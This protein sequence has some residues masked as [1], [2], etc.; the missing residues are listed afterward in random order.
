MATTPSAAGSTEKVAGHEHGRGDPRALVL[1]ALG[2]VYG[3]IGTSPLY[4][5]REAFGHAGGLHLQ[6]GR[7]PRRALARLLVA[8][9]RRHRQV[10]LLSSC[11][12]TTAARAASWRSAPWPR[13]P[14]ATGRAAAA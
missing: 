1:A 3:D 2:V 6:R 10:R 4:A 9:P 7:G 11:A 5:M 14:A 12:P 13:G 8:D